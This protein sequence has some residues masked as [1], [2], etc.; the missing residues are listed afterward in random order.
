MIEVFKELKN[1]PVTL[2]IY[3]GGKLFEHLQQQIKSEKLNINLKGKAKINS[4]LLAHYD[5]FILPSFSE[6][7]PVSLIEAIVTGM[8]SLLSDLPQLR[9]VAKDSAFY[10]NPQTVPE[11]LSY[12]QSI[13]KN[14]NIIASMSEKAKQYGSDFGVSS[15]TNQLFDI[16][17]RLVQ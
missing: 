10:F 9:E 17:N 5:A 11:L 2:D 12:I 4:K 14:K 1:L 16:Y 7:M 3:G 15:Y 13:L 6:G 8:P